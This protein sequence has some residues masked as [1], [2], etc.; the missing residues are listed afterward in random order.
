MD[1]SSIDE[2]MADPSGTIVSFPYCSIKNISIQ[3]ILLTATPSVMIPDKIRRNLTILSQQGLRLR[4]CQF[5][6]RRTWLIW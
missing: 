4:L 1:Q 5:A 3:S 6:I 2:N